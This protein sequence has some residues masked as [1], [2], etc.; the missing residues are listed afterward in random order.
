MSPV[1]ILIIIIASYLLSVVLCILSAKL[2][3]VGYHLNDRLPMFHKGYL[4]GYYCD[5]LGTDAIG[6]VFWMY[7]FVI[8]FNS[9]C[10]LASLLGILWFPFWI[11]F[12]TLLRLL[13]D[14]VDWGKSI[15]KQLENWTN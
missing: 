5:Y 6:E 3:K 15:C 14:V 11:I 9:F 7:R 2:C 1:V 8:I 10:V 4:F 13:F 12:R